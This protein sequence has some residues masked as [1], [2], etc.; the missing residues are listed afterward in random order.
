MTANQKSCLYRLLQQRGLLYRLT[1]LCDLSDTTEQDFIDTYGCTIAEA[2][3]ALTALIESLRPKCR[4][5]RKR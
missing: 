2:E 3:E 4:S 1:S 5:T